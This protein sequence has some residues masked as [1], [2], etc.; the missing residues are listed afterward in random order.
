MNEVYFEEEKK[1]SEPVFVRYRKK[2]K[3]IN[4]RFIV[5]QII[6]FNSYFSVKKKLRKMIKF[7]E[8]YLSHR[9]MFAFTINTF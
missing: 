3:T 1:L 5:T 8:K 2:N 7:E 4:I 9:I 6:S